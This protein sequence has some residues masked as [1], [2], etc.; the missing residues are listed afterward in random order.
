M[1]TATSPER[2]IPRQLQPRGRSC[3]A[4]R[5]QKAHC[6]GGI[7]PQF[8]A[9]F[10]EDA[11]PLESGSCFSKNLYCL[12]Q[13]TLGS[14][15]PSCA[16]GGHSSPAREALPLKLCVADVQA[17][18]TNGLPLTSAS[19]LHMAQKREPRNERQCKASHTEE[20]SASSLSKTLFHCCSSKGKSVL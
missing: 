10:W 13:A 6:W 8:A 1:P 7:L 16:V 19:S 11:S 17:Q 18:N 5:P 3:L 15:S 12:C 14:L 20:H 4:Q 9:V 2:V